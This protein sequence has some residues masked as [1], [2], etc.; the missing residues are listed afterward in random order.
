[1]RPSDINSRLKKFQ[2]DLIPLFGLYDAIEMDLERG[3][4]NRYPL[5]N[6]LETWFSKCCFQK[7]FNYWICDI[8]YKEYP[9]KTI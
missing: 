5:K 9:N 7:G 2:Y 4:V 6:Y 3:G 8:R 1:M